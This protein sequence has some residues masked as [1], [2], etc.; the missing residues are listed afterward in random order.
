[1]MM[2]ETGFDL[3]AISTMSV[4]ALL[5]AIVLY[6][7]KWG[8]PAVLAAVKEQG[9]VFAAEM[10]KTRQDYREDLKEDR[11]EFRQALENTNQALQNN[12]RAID[13]LKES[14]SRGRAESRA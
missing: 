7:V 9:I 11:E 13:A 8:I 5:A 6:L 3:S 10:S 14:M 1:M 2:A 12:T 4:P